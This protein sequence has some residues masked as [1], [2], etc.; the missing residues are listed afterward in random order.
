MILRDPGWGGTECAL[1]S[2]RHHRK[3]FVSSACDKGNGFFGRGEPTSQV[4][5]DC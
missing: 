2:N 3:P 4:P 1:V 5:W